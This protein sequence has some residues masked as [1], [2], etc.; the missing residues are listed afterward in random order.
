MMFSVDE[1][2]PV[3]G[4]SVIIWRSTYHNC[5]LGLVTRLKYRRYQDTILDGGAFSK[6]ESPRLFWCKRS[7]PSCQSSTT[8]SSAEKHYHRRQGAINSPSLS[9]I[10]TKADSLT[11][12]PIICISPIA[13]FFLFLNIKCPF[14]CILWSHTQYLFSL[15]NI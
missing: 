6:L 7:T 12:P 10:G 11:D 8:S 4:G 5:K 13:I 2:V 9:I 3:D 1:T 15:I 14:L